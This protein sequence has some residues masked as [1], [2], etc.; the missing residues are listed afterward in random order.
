MDRRS[1]SVV[2]L[3]RGG[4]LARPGPFPFRGGLVMPDLLGTL[5]S[6]FAGLIGPGSSLLLVLGGLC[7]GFLAGFVSA[8]VWFNPYG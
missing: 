4:L 7:A 5:F 2:P 6:S 3:D 8:R 1:R